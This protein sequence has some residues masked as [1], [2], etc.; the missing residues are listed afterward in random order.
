MTVAQEPVWLWP[1]ADLA[2]ALE[3]L[4]VAAGSVPQ[5]PAVGSAT[6]PQGPHAD[7][8]ERDLRAWLELVAARLGLELG[9]RVLSYAEADLR[10]LPVPSLVALR[11]PAGERAFVA[12]LER[13]RGR[14]RV[15]ARSGEL[16]WI[17]DV[18]LSTCL[19]APLEKSPVVGEVEALLAGVRLSA[20][21]ARA[22]RAELLLRVLGGQP[23][24][25]VWSLALPAS[26]PVGALG[27][28]VALPRTFAAFCVAF[29][30]KMLLTFGSWWV[31]WHAALRGQPS[32]GWLV[33]WSLTVATLQIP[34]ALE[35]WLAGQL[36]LRGGWVLRRRLLA[37][38]LRLEPE[39][40]RHLGVGALLGR[41]LEG[42]RVEHQG[43]QGATLLVSRLI[44]LLV[45]LPVLVA[46]SGGWPHALLLV[47]GICAT[48]LLVRPYLAAKATAASQRLAMAGDLVEKMVGYETRTLQQPASDWH[49]EED[50]ALSRYAVALTAVHRWQTALTW[51]VPGGWIV[52]AFAVIAPGFV[53][54]TVAPVPFAIALGGTL[55]GALAFDSLVRTLV[56]GADAWV[57]WGKVQPL[58]AAAERP[59]EL[60]DPSFVVPA[61]GAPRTTLR[62]DAVGYRYASRD[63]PA[64]DDVSIALEPGAR[65]LLEGPSGSGKSTL[66]AL[67]AGQRAPSRGVVLFDGL[68]RQTL[69]ASG[70]ARRVALAPQFHDNHLF[71]GSLGFNLLLGRGWPPTPRDLQEARQVC[72]ELG[73]GPL[74]ERM[75]GGLGQQVGE[76][77]WQLSHGERSRV[78]VARAL[79]QGADVVCLDESFAALDPESL[80]LTLECVHARAATLIVSAHP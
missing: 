9:A 48:S 25:T 32:P 43:A 64:L 14:V 38:A 36:A 4:A 51:V 2:G 22:A 23:A 34:T 28:E 50:A 76:I 62:A 69:G 47:A 77:G 18:A 6:A 26:A 35:P 27:R 8:S 75:P 58:F 52:L 61:P 46:G 11:T 45:L 49:R 60:G 59:R 37:G 24:S 78:F 40:V 44:A 12:V 5:Y 63:E 31:L 41:S 16:M 39:E 73:L 42:E 17:R 33:A 66:L 54:A 13:R 3:G 79:L 65:V 10:S 7:L 15:L 21:G 68:D 72:A 70:I 55:F 74:L 30:L 29:A 71:L 1:L 19:R 57:A 56:V 53:W 80:R 67:L 20:R